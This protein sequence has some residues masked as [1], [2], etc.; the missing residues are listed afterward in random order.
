MNVRKMFTSFHASKSIFQIGVHSM[1]MQLQP[2]LSTRCTNIQMRRTAAAAR[3]VI[4]NAVLQY[5]FLVKK[6]E[7]FPTKAH[8]GVES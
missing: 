8:R 7:L 4:G 3:N 2:Y 5:L 1:R 6:R